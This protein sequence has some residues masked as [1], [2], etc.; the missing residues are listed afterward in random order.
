[1][2]SRI[3]VSNLSSLATQPDVEGIWVAS[4]HMCVQH[5][6][7]CVPSTRIN[8]VSC[9]SGRH[10]HL[11]MKLHSQERRAFEQRGLV[12]TPEVPLTRA[13]GTQAWSSICANGA[14]QVSSRA[15]SSLEWSF[16][17]M[18]LLI[19]STAWFQ[20]GRG[21]VVGCSSSVGD[22]CSRMALPGVPVLFECT[23]W[24]K[25]CA[26]HSKTEVHL[27]LCNAQAGVQE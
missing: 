9:T 21:P 7:V 10:L 25:R 17:C 20:T 13:E 3:A 8:G 4:I 26:K 11:H 24:C 14:L 1:M 5:T 18:C 19:S 6:Y 16:M 22:P 12:L 15:L 23:F 27:Y 2:C